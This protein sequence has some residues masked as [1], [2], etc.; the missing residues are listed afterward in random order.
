MDLFIWT[1]IGFVIGM[2]ANFIWAI[3]DTKDFLDTY[4]DPDWAFKAG[5][6]TVLII[7]AWPLAIFFGIVAMCLYFIYKFAKRLKIE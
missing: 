7:M 5:F 1:V 2:A 6:F 3:L 4:S